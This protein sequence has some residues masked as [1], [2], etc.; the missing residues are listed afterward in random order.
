M[1]TIPLGTSGRSTTRLGFGCS[2]IM[3]ALGRHDSLNMLEAAWDAGIRHF[4]V[5]PMYGYGEA[6]GCVGEFL[7]RHQGQVTVTT[8]FGIAAKA[9]GILGRIARSAL[10]PIVHRFPGLKQRAR[11]ASPVATPASF[12]QVQTPQPAK[13]PNPIFNA[14]EA[15]KSLYG[16]LAALRAEHID[17][18]L[19]H[20][21]TPRDLTDDALLRFLQDSVKSGAVGT[22]GVGTDRSYIDALCSE[23]PSYCPTL[24]YEWSVFNP[25]VAH[26]NAFH[27][28]HRSLTNNF[29][30]IHADLILKKERCSRWCD[31]IGA[32][33]GDSEVLAKLMLKAALLLNPESVI[34][35]S[36]K[37]PNHIRDNV[38]LASDNSMSA[39][40]MA[41]YRI[42]QAELVVPVQ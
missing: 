8:K 23:H 35:F 3:G 16:S 29:R 40:A 21:V 14:E 19:L 30:S 5:A 36:S 9:G 39:S 26:T 15:R 37:S 22:F 7:Q 25:I 42:V 18:W 10:R 28:H 17:V 38:N 2:S 34:L 24:Q 12:T 11:N 13:P 31:F 4:D 41:L 33:V 20:D 1:D 32:D 27:I 6:E